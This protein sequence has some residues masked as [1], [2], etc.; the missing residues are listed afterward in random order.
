MVGPSIGGASDLINDRYGVSYE[1]G[2]AQAC[3]DAI[4]TALSKN[5]REWAPIIKEQSEHIQ[6]TQGHFEQLFSY[7]ES[8]LVGN[9]LVV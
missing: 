3:A 1:P 4:Q 7:Y 5:R 2:N 6:S 8:V 9:Q